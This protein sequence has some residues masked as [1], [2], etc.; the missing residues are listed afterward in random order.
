MVKYMI[1]ES[2]YIHPAALVDPGVTIGAN[3][4]VW[5]FAHIIS[6]VTIGE[7]CNICDHVFIE[8]KVKIGNRVTIKCGVYLWDGV[9][10]EDDVFIG[11]NATFTNDKYPKSKQYPAEYAKT[12][13]KQGCSIGANA[14]LLS[15]LIIGKGAMVGAG[16]VVTKNVADFALVY[17]NPAVVKSRV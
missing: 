13:L 17:G 2:V 3:T 4:R 1:H 16:S 9:E 5:A 14:T 8:G 15:P 11:P 6:G 10:I 12:I 7:D